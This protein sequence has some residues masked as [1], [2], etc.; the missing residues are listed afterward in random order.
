MEFPKTTGECISKTV[1]NG[2]MQVGAQQGWQCPVCK[3]ILSPWTI[4]CPCKGAGNS[5]TITFSTTPEI[6]NVDYNTNTIHSSC[7]VDNDIMQCTTAHSNCGK[8]FNKESK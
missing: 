8:H 7:C 3:R 1:T 5:Q 4:E 2:F 6:V